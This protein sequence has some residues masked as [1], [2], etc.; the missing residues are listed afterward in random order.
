MKL[1]LYIVANLT[2]HERTKHIDIDCHFVGEKFQSNLIHPLH[3]S[4]SHQLSGLFTKQL[5]ISQF[6]YLL[7]KM[8]VLDLHIPSGEDVKYNKASFFVKYN[9]ASLFYHFSYMLFWLLVS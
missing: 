2:F 3:V 8:G 1:F 6:K 7:S 5:G 4:S 9:R